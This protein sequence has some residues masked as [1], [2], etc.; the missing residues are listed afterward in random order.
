MPSQLWADK[1]QTEFL[2]SYFDE[3]YGLQAAGKYT[4]FWAKLDEAWFAR[5]PAL[6]D[7]F[8]GKKESEL[9]EEERGI[10]KDHI[11]TAKEVRTL[12]LIVKSHSEV[13]PENQTVVPLAS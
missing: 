13:I 5:W 10:L 8:P 6:T 1:E 12:I 9:T 11:K 7:V 2:Q 3:Y 4:D